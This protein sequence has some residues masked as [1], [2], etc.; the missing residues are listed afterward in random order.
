MRDGNRRLRA[1]HALA[2][3]LVPTLTLAL[4]PRAAAQSANDVGAP[5][6]GYPWTWGVYRW[7]EGTTLG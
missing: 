4:P 3:T 5:A 1:G 6:A 7:L 2:L